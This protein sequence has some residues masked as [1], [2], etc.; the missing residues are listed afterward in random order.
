MTEEEKALYNI[1]RQNP[2]HPLFPFL[3]KKNILGEVTPI[4]GKTLKIMSDG[5]PLIVDSFPTNSLNNNFSGDDPFA[6]ISTNKSFREISNE[7]AV[8]GPFGKESI[9]YKSEREVLKGQI[10]K[11]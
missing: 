4:Q 8:E 11:L 2:N 9:F 3:F 1:I 5:V 6:A 7:I 10:P